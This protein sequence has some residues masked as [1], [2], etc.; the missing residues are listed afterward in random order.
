[1]AEMAMG[2]QGCKWQNVEEKKPRE[3]MHC[4]DRYKIRYPNECFF[5]FHY[6]TDM[7]WWRAY[8]Y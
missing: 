1:M 3:L 4:L 6:T 5:L 2:L 7:S 8:H